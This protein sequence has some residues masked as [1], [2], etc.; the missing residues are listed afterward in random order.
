MINSLLIRIA[1]FCQQNKKGSQINI[2]RNKKKRISCSKHCAHRHKKLFIAT[3]K[4]WFCHLKK[5]GVNIEASTE[6]YLIFEEL[7]LIL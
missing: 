6:M 3:R 7:F 4:L 5:F 1:K 2:N